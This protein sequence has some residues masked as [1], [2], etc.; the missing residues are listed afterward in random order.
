MV[1]I[2]KDWGYTEEEVI[3][4]VTLRYSVGFVKKRLQIPFEQTIF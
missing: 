4:E 3:I 1:D 2:L